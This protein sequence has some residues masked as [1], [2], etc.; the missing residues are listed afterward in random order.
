MRKK[1]IYKTVIVFE[2]LS[3]EPITDGLDFEEIA[4]ECIYGD[5][6]GKSEITVKNQKFEG[7]EAV[8]AI[9]AQGSSPEFFQMDEDGNEIEY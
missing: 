9:L 7:N 2:V 3:P 8:S 5:Y 1:C 6:S 4:G